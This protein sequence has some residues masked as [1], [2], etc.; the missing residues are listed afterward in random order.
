MKL[1]EGQPVIWRYQRFKPKRQVYHI[2]AE[3]VQSGSLHARTRILHCS[4]RILLRWVK[5]RNL[6]PWTPE[7]ATDPYPPD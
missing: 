3:I 4:G 7:T 1:C 2:A 6:H 5:L